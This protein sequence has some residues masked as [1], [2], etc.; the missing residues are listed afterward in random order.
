MRPLPPPPKHHSYPEIP[1]LT[2]W[3]KD[4]PSDTPGVSRSQDPA[5]AV[6]DGLVDGLQHVTS[7]GS[8]CYRLAELFFATMWWLNHRKDMPGFKP[9]MDSQR[10]AAMLRLNLCAANK[11]ALML[12]CPVSELARELQDIYGVG[13]VGHG[14]K[15]DKEEGGR[16][17]SADERERWRVIFKKGMAYHFGFTASTK[18]ELELWNTG[19]GYDSSSRAGVGFVMSMSGDLFA[20]QFGFGSLP[21]YHS[22]FMSGMPVLCAGTICIESGRITRICNDSGHYA[23]V[24]MSLSKVLQRLRLCGVNLTQITVAR[25]REGGLSSGADTRGDLFLACNGDWN[26]IEKSGTRARTV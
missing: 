11:L 17:M 20:G 4:S 22:S 12:W 23:P 24:D 13:M 18:S 1:T 3:E 25:V 7:H 14:I 8:R 10:R 26:T 15:T 16:Y 21:K 9:G 5:L 19:A 2:Q 6:I